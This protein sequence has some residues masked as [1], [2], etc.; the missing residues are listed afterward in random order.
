MTRRRLR[1]AWLLGLAL[2]SA[3]HLEPP[4][5]RTNPFDPGADIV[6]RMT[7]PDSAT[8]IN[9]RVQMAV[10]SSEPMPEGPLAVNWT[11]N[12]PVVLLS[13]G[14]GEFLVS[15]ASARFAEYTVIAEFRSV[16]VT[17]VI[18]V[19][20]LVTSL[21]LSC[22]PAGQP[23]LP[24]DASPAPLGSIVSVYPIMTDAGGRAVGGAPYAV[25]RA[26]VV[27]RDSAVALPA[28]APDGSGILR[29]TAAGMGST[30]LIVTI[31]QATDSVRV[32]VGP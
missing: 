6:L 8:A 3:C 26:Q 30:W 2:T 12:N 23:P 28:P 5:A 9:Q 31:D 4:F 1:N 13:L 15:Y 25:A 29:I 16:L 22:A 32:A 14:N 7:G 11:S 10:V 21:A 24:C 19:G 17:G 27:S 20:Q 18:Q